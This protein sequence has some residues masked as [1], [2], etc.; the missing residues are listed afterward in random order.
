MIRPRRYSCPH[1]GG[2]LSRTVFHP[3][4]LSLESDKPKFQM[5]LGLVILSIAILGLGLGF[6]HPVLGFVAVM[7]ISSWIYWRYF[8]YLKCDA[9]SRYYFGGQLKGGPQGTRPWTK[10]EFKALAFKIA[11]V[12]VVMLILS[13]PFAYIER[14]TKKH[15]VAACA[16]ANMDS[17]VV[18]N[19]CK[20]VQKTK[21]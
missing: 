1:C 18:F 21:R 10:S 20:C 9:C 14:L 2:G 11:A 3:Q 5:P 15:C 8:S 19:K 7:A 13:L 4:W 16:E 12:C 17:Q 6:I